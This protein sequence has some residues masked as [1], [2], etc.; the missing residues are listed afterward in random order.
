MGI[1]TAIVP[2]KSRDVY[3]D[4]IVSP[5]MVVVCYADVYTPDMYIVNT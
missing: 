2:D 4:I 1:L 5:Y 3:N